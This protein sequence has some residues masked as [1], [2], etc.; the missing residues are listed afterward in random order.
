M[1]SSTRA[2]GT[3][4]CVASDDLGAPFCEKERERHRE[5]RDHAD[6]EI[7]RKDFFGAHCMSAVALD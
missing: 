6:I 1:V 7:H 2:P 3:L 5:L 4:V